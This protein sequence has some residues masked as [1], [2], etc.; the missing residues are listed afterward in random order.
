MKFRNWLLK[1]EVSTSTGDIA[2]FQRPIMG[3]VTRKWLGPW[4]DEDPFFK[5]KKKISEVK[6]ACN[7]N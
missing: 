1:L 4:A 2:G 7:E 3:M 6:E 5:K